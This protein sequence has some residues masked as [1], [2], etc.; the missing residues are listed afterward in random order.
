MAWNYI[1]TNNF[2]NIIRIYLDTKYQNYGA[3]YMIVLILEKAPRRIFYILNLV[4]CEF[5][6]RSCQNCYYANSAIRLGGSWW[7]ACSNPGRSIE[8]EIQGWRWIRSQLNLSC[9]LDRSADSTL[10]APPR[11]HVFTTKLSPR[12]SMRRKRNPPRCMVT[13]PMDYVIRSKLL[14]CFRRLVFKVKQE[15][16]SFI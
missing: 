10:K 15:L 7:C 1:Y 8:V 2:G 11:L 4:N 13:V 6:M 3:V 5:I 16:H 14:D 12:I 9:W